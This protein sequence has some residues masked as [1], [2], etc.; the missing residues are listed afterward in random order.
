MLFVAVVSSCEQKL[1]WLVTQ[2]LD[3]TSGGQLVFASSVDANICATAG[4]KDQKNV[5]FV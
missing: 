2:R 1:C 5:L 4:R 3:A